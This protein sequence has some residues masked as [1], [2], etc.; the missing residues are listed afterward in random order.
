MEPSIFNKLLETLEISPDFSRTAINSQHSNNHYRYK[1][2]NKNGT[3]VYINGNIYFDS[4]KD[5]HHTP[6]VKDG[7]QAVFLDDSQVYFGQL[8]KI[9]R[10][11]FVALRNVYYLQSLDSFEKGNELKLIKLGSE[12]HGPTDEMNINVSKIAFWEQL[13]NEGSVVSAILKYE[14]NQK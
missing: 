12:V 11:Q 10:Q 7:F 3:Q 14:R 1:N 8:E 5:R 2:I 13:K 6:V 4:T 9:N